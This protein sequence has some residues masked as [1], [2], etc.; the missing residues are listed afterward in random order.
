MTYKL[1]SDTIIFI[2]LHKVVLL[3][4]IKDLNNLISTENLDLANFI[5]EESHTFESNYEFFNFLHEQ[6]LEGNLGDEIVT[7]TFITM[8]DTRIPEVI[9]ELA[10]LNYGSGSAELDKAILVSRQFIL[11][12][13]T[14]VSPRFEQAS[15][16]VVS[17]IPIGE[18]EHID[19]AD[20]MY[21]V[22]IFHDWE[23]EY[24]PL[25][26]EVFPSDWDFE[27]LA[28]RYVEDVA[29]SRNRHNFRYRTS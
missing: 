10:H 8:Q 11:S 23:V 21:Q 20:G 3:T 15:P 18:A 19:Y 17:F 13:S 16:I 2:T 29:F 12:S 6:A 24:M 25:F 9:F 26:H 27:S 4:F 28:T 14:W 1:F 22:K 7:Q 5:F